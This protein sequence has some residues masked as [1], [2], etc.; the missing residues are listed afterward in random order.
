MKKKTVYWVPKIGV[1]TVLAA[2]FMA[3][4][5]VLRLIWAGGE[6]GVTRGLFWFQI[7]LPLLANVSFEII[8][9]RDGRDRLYRTA[10]PVWLGCVF[11]AVKALGFP[12]MIHTI[13]CLCLYALVA[14]LFTATVT[15]YVGTQKLLWPLFGLPML[16][17]IFVEDTQKV[18][19]PLHDW[20]PELSVLCCM[21]AL[22]C[23]SLAMKKKP[24]EEGEYL[25]RFGDRND[26][27]RLR[28]L[29]PIFAV[30]PY[31]MK[32]RNTSQNF[33]EDHME[34]SAVERYIVEK[35]K[36]G[37]KYF[38]IL[39]VL[40]AAYVRTC[41][42]YPGLNRFIAGQKIFTRD[43]E[44]EVNMTIKKEMS[45]D[46]P[47]TV[48]KVTFDPADTPEAVYERF[49]EKVREVK[50]A[51]ADT[52]FDKLAGGFNLIPGLLLKFFVFLLQAMDYFG[53]LPRFL[54]KLSPF[55]GS[56]YIT[57][58]ASLGIPPIYHHLYDFGNVPVFCSFGKKRRVW[59]M[60]RDGSPVL[61]KYIDCNFVTDERIV[62]GF[63]FA[64]ALR[65]LHNL[66]DDP[67]QL[68]E[69]AAEIVRDEN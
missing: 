57:S 23:L 14:F 68:D 36:A 38:G 34:I 42:R 33:I 55:H 17:H 47:D 10:V 20:L 53:L 8:L 58:M 49:N 2:L 7:V 22:L 13:L 28:G 39:H 29:S 6:T 67:W 21:A 54:T 25:K 15:G 56:L 61:R 9:F 48:I 31:L 32:T 52:G 59:E 27:R 65:Y 1:L 69:P 64:S 63:Y 3:A 11:F 43:R 44:I 46:S 45:T 16:Y 62:D 35:R 26:G 37:M 50:D 24:V 19:W 51:P 66:M 60:K 4:S 40:L 5:A 18:G 30:S 12:S 41:A